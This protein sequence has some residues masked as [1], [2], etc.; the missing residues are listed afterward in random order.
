MSGFGDGLF[1]ISD[2]DGKIVF[3]SPAV[4]A[5]T[6]RPIGTIDA[7]TWPALLH[8]DDREYARAFYAAASHELRSFAAWWRVR[9]HDGIFVWVM[10]TC[11]SMTSE[12]SG[13]PVAYMG[14]MDALAHPDAFPCAGGLVGP[15]RA[16]DGEAPRSQLSRVERLADLTLMS[17]SLAREIGDHEIVEALD[18]ALMK[19][20]FSLAHLTKPPPAPPQQ[21]VVVSSGYHRAPRQAR[22][23]RRRFAARG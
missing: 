2:I 23:T 7:S 11:A 20:G 5:F 6:G 12:H 10:I 22:T 9:R 15:D 13:E 18:A 3:T 1:F 21:S 17:A 19:I 16:C 8:P 14:T 4:H